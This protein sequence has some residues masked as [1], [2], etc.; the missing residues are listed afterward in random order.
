MQY[1]FWTATFALTAAKG[2]VN[3]GMK[4]FYSV[5]DDFGSVVTAEQVLQAEQS[6][7]PR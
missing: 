3:A 7:L 6:S 2:P 5:L 4:V 1:L